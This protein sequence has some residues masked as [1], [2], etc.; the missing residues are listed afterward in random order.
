MSNVEAPG[1]RL[2]FE[3]HG[4]GPLMVM[5]PGA[6][7]AADAFRMAASHLAAHYTVVL[8]DRRGFSRSQLTEAQDYSHRLE[9]D[10]DD[11]RRLIQHLGDR[12]IVFGASSGAIVALELLTRHPDI[13][14][15][16]VPFEPPA[17]KQLSDGQRWLNFFLEVYDLYRREGVEPAMT[18]FRERAFAESD[19]QAM[20]QG[21]D[22]TNE[23]VIANARYWFE[24]ELRQYP[25]ADLDLGELT[26]HADRITL[27]LGRESP[28]TP[29]HDVTVELS[30]KLGRKPITLPGG[31][32][33]CITQ[34]VEFATEL[35]QALAQAEGP[36]A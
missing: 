11:V 25:A 19:R 7:G 13:V 12:A 4:G 34:P 23:Q 29:A 14:D 32:I 31:H 17:V 6:N 33:G 36:R 15:T 24:H 10:A 9:T 8:Y 22:L 21:V 20:A 35:R 5:I 30:K 27:A 16:L 2:Y 1:A 26:D 18:A 28:G 3:I